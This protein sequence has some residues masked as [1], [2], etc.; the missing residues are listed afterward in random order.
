MSSCSSQV[1]LKVQE[2]RPLLGCSSL[3][4]FPGA[5][6][7]F[8]Y[9]PFRAL[10]WH[11][12]L[13]AAGCR[14]GSKR[15]G[16]RGAEAPAVLPANPAY[17]LTCSNPCVGSKHVT[18]PSK[19]LS[20]YWDCSILAGPFFVRLP[21]FWSLAHAPIW[22]HLIWVCVVNI[23]YEH[24]LNVRKTQCAGHANENHQSMSN[25]FEHSLS[26]FETCIKCFVLMFQRF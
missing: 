21:A 2:F 17:P 4:S 5:L 19:L 22:I 16:C 25:L 11:H 8:G 1:Q 9:W 6:F 14:S 3:F 18:L 10:C 26:C 20:L 12:F 15:S 13:S 23:L 7:S 24:M